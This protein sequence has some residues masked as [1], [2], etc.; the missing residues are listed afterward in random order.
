MAGDFQ[1]GILK[2]VD[3]YINKYQQASGINE[4]FNKEVSKWSLLLML[5]RF[6]PL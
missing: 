4:Q 6:N 3:E 1:D 2:L 5:P